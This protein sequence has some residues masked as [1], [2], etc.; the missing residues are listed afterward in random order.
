M[1]EE[2]LNQV[3][4]ALQALYSNVD[5]SVKKEASDFLQNFQRSQEAWSIVFPVLQNDDPSALQL[6]IFAAQTLRSKVN[7]DL[8]QVPRESLPS[9]KESILQSII[10]FDTKQKLISTQLCIALANFSLQYLDWKNAV[11]EIVNALS[12]TA[13]SSLLEF[14][15][16]LPEELSDVK[17]TP[18]TDEEFRV[19]SQEL[20]TDN[21]EQV[22]YI[23]TS[24]AGSKDS[25]GG[26]ANSLV[27][28][29][30]NSWIKEVPL[31]QVLTNNALCSLVFQGVLDV[32]TFEMSI[33][34]LCTLIQETRD[35]DNLVVIK[36]LYEQLMTLR[37]MITEDDPEQLE[38]FTRLFVEAGEAWHVYVA[39]MPEEFAPL[40]DV[41]LQLTSFDEDLDIVKYT[42]YFW[43][44]LKQLIVM[45]KFAH[46]RQVY[47]PV[48]TKLLEV[49]ISHLRY[50]VV[51]GNESTDSSVL[52]GD[53][54]REDKFKDFRYEMGD[55][56]K[57]C[58]AVIGTD[59]AL[60]IPLNI[61]VSY[62]ESKS[63]GVIV[64]WQQAEAAIFSLRAM[65]K[66]VGTSEQNVLPKIMTLLVQLPE[67]PKTR[68]A[69]TLVLGRYT[70]WTARHSNFLEPQLDYIIKGFQLADTEVNTAAAH[71]L[72][73]FCQ[74]CSHLLI[75]Y[76]E[77][78]FNF[79]NSVYAS[80]DLKSLY[81]VADG[82]GHIL[83]E[84]KNKE[85]LYN[86]TLMFWK[87]TL[88]TLQ[89]FCDNI[90]KD[91]KTLEETHT[92]IA[93]TIEVISA[94]VRVLKPRNSRDTEVPVAK[95]IV[96]VCWPLVA[97]LL[98]IYGESERV[99]ERCSKFMKTSMQS[100]SLH[101]IPVI[102]QTAELLVHGFEKFHYG[103]YLWVS[104]IFIREYSDE[105]VP[106]EIRESVWQF[107]IQQS[108]N[109]MRFLDERKSNL[110]NYPD[111]VED[112][113]RMVSDI[114]MFFP[115]KFVD[116]PLL[117]SS[118][119]TALAA[120]STLTQVDPISNTLEFLI[121]LFSWGFETPPIS[122]V[123]EVPAE[124]QLKLR[125]FTLQVGQELTTVLMTGLIY[126]FPYD[127]APDASDL[128]SK[129]I[130]LSVSQNTPD[131]KAGLIWLDGSIQTLPTGSVNEKE[132]LKLLATVETAI[133]S[134]DFRRVRAS[135][136]DF[137]NWYSRKNINRNN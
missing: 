42:F 49:M 32:D 129:I 61:L 101:L 52:F 40:A 117:T 105:V 39:K 27:L 48:Y 91:K 106:A 88:E 2:T 15:Q 99:S 69:A 115:F 38:A 124:V 104:G 136:H 83:R 28:S 71:A 114:L 36:A 25:N 77:Q 90:P 50:P 21:V 68:Y 13:V 30:L 10:A 110:A 51:E 112:F 11:T 64:P 59:T 22:L 137:V 5:S 96:E 120:L 85:T 65:A 82:I 45:E 86:I 23:L 97:K 133:N 26:S 34:C 75:N 44:A 89:G 111:L 98:S 103:C 81:E 8:S 12:A 55:V 92:K 18:L 72:M 118:F 19:R 17:K 33:D 130:K 74:D 57:D 87:P 29:C 70:E 14:L 54:E 1:S 123:D 7:Y 56:L 113:F 58:C 67:N 93:D 6:R 132:R 127:C 4:N 47:V 73:Y 24:F 16:V 131:A 134:K 79:Y 53:R 35:Y 121:D 135:I 122:F 3:N 94:F 63:R 109:F 37:P 119:S 31:D 62:V 95:I 84:E 102:S 108:S 116:S 125:Q 9:L 60:G 43:Y 126:S 20:L 76:L 80:L 128:L 107:S 66:E 100:F 46:S 78:L 41:L